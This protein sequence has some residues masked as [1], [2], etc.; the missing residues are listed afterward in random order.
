MLRLADGSRADRK[1]SAAYSRAG[2]GRA[3]METMTAQQAIEKLEKYKT[4]AEFAEN[5]IYDTE[6]H[7]ACAAAPRG[8]ARKRG[9]E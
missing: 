9:R 7:N 8:G 5:N 3:D 6:L 1:V 4:A 2:R